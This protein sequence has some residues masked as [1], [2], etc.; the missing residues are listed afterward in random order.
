MFFL[1]IINSVHLRHVIAH[2]LQL[3]GCSHQK[4]LMQTGDVAVECLL[5]ARL[6]MLVHHES[7]FQLLPV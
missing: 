2:T 7:L 5:R 1:A 6:Q 4:E 3:H